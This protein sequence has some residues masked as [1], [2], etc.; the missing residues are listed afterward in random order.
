[1]WLFPHDMITEVELPGSIGWVSRWQA[2]RW[3][4]HLGDTLGSAP[5]VSTC[6]TEGKEA[7][8]V[9]GCLPCSFQESPSWSSREILGLHGPIELPL[10]GVRRTVP[11]L[12]SHRIQAAPGSRMTDPGARW[13][14]SARVGPEDCWQLRAVG[15]QHF[16][17]LGAW[18]T[19]LK[20][21]LGGTSPLWVK[22]NSCDVNWYTDQL[23]NDAR[24]L[25][26]IC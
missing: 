4:L 7:G 1:M 22:G 19:F 3:R 23:I 2:L 17:Q 18:G 10:A 6:D 5:G 26:K 11:K 14:S 16:Q 24:L 13:L 21:D 25:S 8:L 12:I 20:G 15:Q 9:S